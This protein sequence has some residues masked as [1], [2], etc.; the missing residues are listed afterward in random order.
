MALDYGNSETTDHPFLLRRSI[1]MA[2]SDLEI[3]VTDVEDGVEVQTIIQGQAPM[4]GG[5]DDLEFMVQ[6]EVETTTEGDTLTVE[7]D[8]V[9]N[10]II[11]LQQSDH[12]HLTTGG[13]FDLNS[14]DQNGGLD[15]RFSNELSDP[16]ASGG[17]T[18]SRR[19]RGLLPTRN[20]S[21]GGMTAKK[22]P[23]KKKG[24]IRFVNRQIPAA[25]S[26]AGVAKE[27]AREANE[28]SFDPEK[29]PRKWKKRRIPVKTIDGGKF[30]V[31]MWCSGRS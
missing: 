14:E 16:G 23:R 27:A 12:H 29:E 6:E 1:K 22:R 31:S 13:H 4:T 2:D 7:L 21:S 20:K 30:C 3:D 8:P 11:A 19:K 26:G 10:V 15:V 9:D 18:S 25:L 28:A 24:S 17:L 5:E